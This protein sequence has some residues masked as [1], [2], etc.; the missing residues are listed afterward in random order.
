MTDDN[1]TGASD[2]LYGVPAIAKHLNLGDQ[3]VY[4][5]AAINRLPTFKIGRRICA[6]KSSLDAWLAK[7]EAG[8]GA[9]DD[10]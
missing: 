6:R 4:H 7:M 3:Q 1:E 2:L 8:E 10:K 9:A 5:L